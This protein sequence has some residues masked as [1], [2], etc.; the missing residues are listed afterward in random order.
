MAGKIAHLTLNQVEKVIKPGLNVGDLF[1][2]IE[3]L[4]TKK[5]D[6]AFPPNI[7]VNETAAHD[8]AAINEKRTL[9][10]KALVKID[11]GANVNGMLSD[12]ARTFSLDGKNSRLIKASKDALKAAIDVIKPGIRLNVIGEVVQDTI[13]S[14]GYKPI[15]NLTGHQL[16]K[17]YLHAGVS[18][19]S[20]K[21]APFSKNRAKL[22]AGMILAIEPFATNGKGINSGY[23]GDAQRP[24][25][26]WSSRG[27]PKTEIGKLLIKRYQKVPF[28]LRSANRYL[29]AQNVKFDDLS[30]ILSKDNFHGYKPLVEKTG[31]LVSQAEHSVLVTSKG[32][33]IIT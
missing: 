14:F 20:V 3:S 21:S 25:L 9:S 32:C 5:A 31:G 7:S 17:G 19:P 16:D 13:E 6:L 24:A 10:K 1:D 23:V 8:S 11:V 26:I 30:K 18:I 29:L 27:K 28:A 2:V 22:K 12:T 15:A 33:R 4:I